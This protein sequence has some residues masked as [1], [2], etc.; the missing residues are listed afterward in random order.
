MGIAEEIKLIRCNSLL[1]Q[2]DFA[3]KLGV[4]FSTVNRWENGKSVPNYQ[5]LKKIKAYCELNNIPF[6]VNLHM[7]RD[8]RFDK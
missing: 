1:S 2:T 8:N 6:T 4:S 7:W 5:T 3:E